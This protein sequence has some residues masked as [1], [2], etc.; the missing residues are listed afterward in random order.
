MSVALIGAYTAAAVAVIGAVFTGLA[1]WQHAR[2][3]SAHG[4][5]GHPPVQ[6]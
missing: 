3:E 2:D 6:P 5:Q 4:G 1:Q